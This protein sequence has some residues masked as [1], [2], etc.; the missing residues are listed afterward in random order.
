MDRISGLFCFF[1][2]FSK[3]LGKHG[4]DMTNG[5]WTKI[6]KL[7]GV[8]G[9]RVDGTVKAGEAVTLARKDGGTTVVWV[10]QVVWSRDGV[11]VASISR[12]APV[13]EADDED[14]AAYAAGMYAA[15][16]AAERAYEAYYDSR[17]EGECF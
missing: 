13:I 7:G 9:A 8:W 1:S 10:D 6:V 4:S 5:T 2:W 16:A 17:S 3:L 12:T 14:E 15:E 11:T